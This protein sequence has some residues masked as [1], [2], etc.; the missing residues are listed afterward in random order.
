M[1]GLISTPAISYLTKRFNCDHGIVISASHNPYKYNGIKFFNRNG[2]K[3]SDLSEKKIEKNFFKFRN[4][5]FKNSNKGKINKIKNPLIIYKKKIFSDLKTKISPK[6]KLKIVIDCANGS[7]YRISK[8]IFSNKRINF[9]FV[10]EKPNGRNINQK[11]GSL[12]PERVVKEVKQRSAD[13]G[14]SFDGDGDRIICCDEKGQIID[15]DKILA[16][17]VKYFFNKNSKKPNVII[18]TVMSNM[19]LEQFISNL[20]LK[21]YRASVGDKFV[22]NL[23]IKKKSYIGGE[24]SGHIILRKFSPS[25]DGI[26]I[27]LQL[28]K[29][30]SKLN[31]KASEIFNLYSPY[32]QIQKNIKLKDSI[33][34]MNNEIKKIAKIYNSKTNKNF[35][36]LIRFSGTEPVLRLL[37]EGKKISIIKKLC[38]ELETELHKII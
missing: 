31:K 28:I 13:F 18:G 30:I 33:Y 11:C 12:Y 10:N 9:I 17:L 14:I 19:G 35:R 15:G 21:F 29:I 24:Q 23:M 7:T 8:Y 3:L 36:V 2:E 4:T 22:Y 25:G 27:A 34:S 20:G 32:Y 1:A 38:K 5:D 37:V 16:C 6:K 26:L